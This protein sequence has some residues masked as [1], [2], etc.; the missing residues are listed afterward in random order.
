MPNQAVIQ[1]NNFTK[2]STPHTFRH[3]F[4]THLLERGT[5][6]RYIQELLG[7]SS[8]ETTA[9]Y[10]QVSNKSLRR[11]ENP[12]DAILRDKTLT[13]KQINKD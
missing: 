1:T 7:H 6:T 5:D 2:R 4:A 12:L 11:I 8:P 9:I 3:S 13:N 10:A